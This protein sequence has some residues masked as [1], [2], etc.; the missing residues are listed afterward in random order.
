MSENEHG[1][2]AASK[3]DCGALIAGPLLQRIEGDVADI[4]HGGT[5]TAP[6]TRLY[7]TSES[8]V[9]ALRQVL[10]NSTTNVFHSIGAPLELHYL[11]HFVFKVY[12]YQA[13]QL[14][15]PCAVSP[16]S[17]HRRSASGARFATGPLLSPRG[18]ASPLRAATEPHCNRRKVSILE[19][20]DIRVTP[21]VRPRVAGDAATFMAAPPIVVTTPSFSTP[22]VT[23]ALTPT[24]AAALHA[25]SASSIVHA[26]SA[27]DEEGEE[28]M[29]GGTA[30]AHDGSVTGN[31]TTAGGRGDASQTSDRG[32][33]GD[34]S[35]S[36]GQ[37]IV[38][39]HFSTG[40]DTN[41]FGIVRN[42]HVAY[43][44]VTP[45]IRIHNNLTLRAL[46]TLVQEA[47]AVHRA[48]Q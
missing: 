46:H 22:V 23:P 11:S 31:T 5:A 33:H 15:P 24:H 16:P 27:T 26:G 9:N 30:S 25:R 42:H 43:E 7:F 21:V 10:Y 18:V 28:H 14:L 37:Y 36:A 39:V 13:S 20:D 35:A 48:G 41:M 38:E 40:M 12:R 29:E 34:S 17:C 19:P 2:D 8:H 1:I 6:K 3:F 47:E 45:M 44:A 32:G 4:A